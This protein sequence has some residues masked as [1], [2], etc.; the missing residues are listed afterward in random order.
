[1]TTSSRPFVRPPLQ[2]KVLTYGSYQSWTDLEWSMK[3]K[4]T[5]FPVSFNVALEESVELRKP[6]DSN[7]LRLTKVNVPPHLIGTADVEADPGDRHDNGPETPFAKQ[8][9]RARFPA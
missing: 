6:K 8:K 5:K 2:A 7:S 1:M 4:C 3:A 9:N